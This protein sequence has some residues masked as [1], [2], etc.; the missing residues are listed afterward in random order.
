MRMKSYEFRVVNLCLKMSK[1]IFPLILYSMVHLF[2]YSSVHNLIS[3]IWTTSNLN[4]MLVS[5]TT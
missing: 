2:N 5:F 4:N 3:L 1:S